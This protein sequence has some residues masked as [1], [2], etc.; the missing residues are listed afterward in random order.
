MS[1]PTMTHRLAAE[2]VGTFWLALGGCGAAVFAAHPTEPTVVRHR[3]GAGS[4]L[5]LL[6]TRNRLARTESRIARQATD[7]EQ[8][9][10]PMPVRPERFQ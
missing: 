10:R 6:Q 7:L 5:D 1:A 3:P 9:Y 8:P 4:G 2:T